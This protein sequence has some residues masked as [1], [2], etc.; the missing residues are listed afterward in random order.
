MSSS[1]SPGDTAVP[2]APAAVKSQRVLACVLCQ[3]RKVKCDRKFPCSGCAKHNVQCIPATQTRRRRRRFPERDLLARLRYYEELL[4]ANKIK[5]DPLHGPSPTAHDDDDKDSPQ[6]S[7]ES[8]DEQTE[9][10]VAVGSSPPPAAS[11]QAKDFWQAMGSAFRDTDT[12]TDIETLTLGIS[13]LMVH[14]A[15]NQMYDNDEHLLFGS[16]NSHSAVDLSTLHPEPI[17]IFR[18]WQVYLDNVN[19][20]L[21]VTHTPTL[22]GRIVEAASKLGGIDPNLEALMFSI[23][24]MA[25][26]SLDN[27]DCESMF[28]LAKKDLSTKY[29]FACHQALSNASFLRCND[30]DCL[31]ALFLYLLSVRTQTMPS[32]LSS[33][34]SIAIRIAERMGL[35]S[36]ADLA[37][38]SVL[39]AEMRRR[40]WWSLVIFDHRTRE[41]THS[42]TTSL[43]PTWDCKVPLNV[44]DSDLR[45]EMKE[46]PVEEA[47]GKPTEALFAVVR[48]EMADFVRNTP[49]HLEFTMPIL[50]PIAQPLPEGGDVGALHR[51]IEEKHL[52]NCDDENPLQFMAKWTVRSYIAKNRLLA[53]YAQFS[54]PPAASQPQ[55][56]SE[57]QR[58]AALSYALAMLQCDEKMMGSPLTKGYRFIHDDNF[59]FPAHVYVVQEL[60]RRPLARHA[61]QIWRVMSDSFMARFQPV[62]PQFVP[63]FK[64]FGNFILRAWDAFEA[65][66]KRSMNLKGEAA[67]GEDAASSDLTPPPMVPIIREMLAEMAQEEAQRTSEA[68]H[69]ST[70][71]S[72]TTPDLTTSG[73]QQ[74]RQQQRADGHGSGV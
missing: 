68:A 72:A 41:K 37:K 49:S 28:G 54:N 2:A 69:A 73:G 3:Q 40:L 45:P 12:T 58:A 14:T 66:R 1:R 38:H 24:S 20:L 30:R 65:A 60:R 71:A 42:H 46:P 59:P 51:L 57:T 11:Y 44:N 62:D 21:K 67:I 7:Y 18:L 22:Q 50:K 4:S 36:E 34:L 48:A 5:F 8:G 13:R 15:M 47:H 10:V 35:D 29:Q 52:K 64:I 31:T 19:P 56:P 33:L 53:Y 17:Q 74:R 39:E 32:S 26:L 43:V 61:Q 9:A 23:Y 6:G 25:I 27:D 70:A 63:M 55:P 16:R